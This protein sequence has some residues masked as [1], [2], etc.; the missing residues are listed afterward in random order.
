MSEHLDFVTPISIRFDSPHIVYR[1]KRSHLQGWR[2][3]LWYSK[4]TWT[5]IG[6]RIVKDIYHSPKVERRWYKWEMPLDM[7]LYYTERF[8]QNRDL[9]VDP[10]AGSFTTAVAAHRLGRRYLGCDHD[11]ECVEIGRRRLA[12]EWCNRLLRFGGGGTPTPPPF[13]FSETREGK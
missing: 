1:G 4:G 11:P 9:V 2:P 6:R 8:T 12:L 3:L 10:F 13:F 5:Q 7:T